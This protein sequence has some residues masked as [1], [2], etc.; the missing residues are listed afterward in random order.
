MAD[1]SKQ[2][3]R[4]GPLDSLFEEFEQDE[5]LVMDGYDDCIVG[6]V[7]RY[8]LPAIICYDKLMVIQKLIDDGMSEDEAYEFWSFNQIGAWLGEGTPCYM[9][10]TDEFLER[11]APNPICN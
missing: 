7:E 2:T 10:P 9:T 11:K 4:T 5:L 8:G 3:D 1:T 6:V